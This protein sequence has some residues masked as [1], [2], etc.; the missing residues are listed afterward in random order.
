MLFDRCSLLA[1]PEVVLSQCELEYR[2]SR[3]VLNQ[4]ENEVLNEMKRID[5]WLR[6]HLA[7]RGWAEQHTFYSKRSFL[8]DTVAARP[9]LAPDPGR[10][11][12]A[13]RW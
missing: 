6:Y 8:R 9:D 4:D 11:T 7:A 10:R 3:S 1:A 2:R 12:A 13:S 5:R